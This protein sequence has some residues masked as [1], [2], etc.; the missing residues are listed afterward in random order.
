VGDENV[1]EVQR[2]APR[3]V[4]AGRY[5]LRELVGTGGMGTVWLA[6]DELLDRDVAVKRVRLV[7]L[8]PVE[9][10][11]ARDRTL[12]EARIAA[13]LHH[14]HIVTIFDVVQENNEPWLVLEFLPSR[15]LGAAT[16][17][18]TCM[19][20]APPCTPRW[21]ATRPSAGATETP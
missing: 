16:R 11:I 18:A 10:A 15:S 5:R 7:D 13:K 2:E 1:N 14:P 17:A 12:S 19:R 8:P 20:S 4:I 21:R 9:A 6:T 3:G